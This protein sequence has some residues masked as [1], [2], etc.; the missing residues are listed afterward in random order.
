LLETH[1]KETV[2]FSRQNRIENQS[3][4]YI[5]Y[6]ALYSIGDSCFSLLFCRWAA[7]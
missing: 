6:I 2:P 7:G 1:Q 4:P 5:P 3:V